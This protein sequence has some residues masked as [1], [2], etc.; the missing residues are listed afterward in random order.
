VIA[1]AYLAIAVVL[2]DALATRWFRPVTWFHRLAAAFLIGLLIATWVTYLTSLLFDGRTEDP[3]LV[4]NLASGWALALAAIA[5][6]RWVP[7]RPDAGRPRRRIRAWDVITL[8]AI[9]LLVTWMMTSTYSYSNGELGIATGLWSDF[10]PTTAIAQNFALG[11]NFPTEYPHYAGEAIRYHFLFYFQVGNLTYLGLDPA[12]ANNVLSIGSMLAMLVLVTALG[13]RLFRNAAVGRIGAALFF[14]HGAL[15]FI[16]YLAG[17]GSIDRIINDVPNLS[18]FL[19][20]G[21]PYRGEEWGIWSQIVFLNQRH[22]ASAIGILLVIVIFLLDRIDRDERAAPVAEPAPVSD[23]EPTVAADAE[24]ALAADAVPAADEAAVD[25][26]RHPVAVVRETLADPWLGGYVLCGALAGMLPLWNGAMFIGAAALLAVWLVIF[27]RRPSM[28]VL[29]VVA[30]VVAIPQLLWVRPGTMA[31]AQTYPSFYWG[32]IVDDPNLFNVAR[33]LAFTFGPKLLLVAFAFVLVTWRERRVLIAFVALGAVAFLLQL[34]VEVL[35]NHKFINAWLIVANLFVAYGLIRLWQARS[36]VAV[37]ARFVALGL[38]VIIVAGG[39]IDLM[40]VKNQFVIRVGMQGDRL[41]EWVRNETDRNAVFLTDLHVVHRIL[42][43]GRRI[44]FGW[45]YY[46]WSAGYAVRERED[47]Y[48]QLFA[49][50]SP[51]DVVER[52]QAAGIDYVAFDDGLRERGFAQR[53]NQEVFDGYLQP[54]FTDP[55]NRYNNTT[56][57]RVPT[58]P[59]AT[60]DLPDAPAEDMY[61]GGTGS[62][63]GQFAEPRGIALDKLKHIYVADTGNGRVQEF[64]SDGSLVRTIGQAGTGEGQ[65]D[66]PTGVAVT[67]NGH[68][69][70]A[71]GDGRV[72]E[73]DADGTHVRETRGP[74]PGFGPLADIVA[75][76]NRVFVLDPDNGRVVRIDENG[77]EIAFGSVGDGPDQLREPT[78][79][80]ASSS[81]IYVADTGNARVAVFN[82]DGEPRE[83]WSVPE[84]V[85]TTDRTADVTG[86]GAGRVWLTNPAGDSILVYRDGASVGT[87]P[88]QDPPIDDPAGIVSAPGNALFV[89]NRTPGRVSMVTQLDP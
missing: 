86:D 5:V 67:T 3:L 84:W 37:P 21:F 62:A 51:R 42:L 89:V 61:T 68:I 53:M 85:G 25:T 35:A 24:P 73:Y 10:G 41:F 1:L 34:S 50:R 70:V 14:F 52:L 72:H 7:R 8:V 58:E 9:G 22:L 83:T 18:A 43:A 23:N 54:V 77:I 6:Y 88:V 16:P 75:A 47:W 19:A 65:L 33:Y 59:A 63:P 60:L 29:A 2:G 80:G 36:V 49:D 4:G 17:L 48:R 40:P 30:S 71:T 57:Y 12:T 28:L 56:V 69:H 39:V 74:A 64:S 27:P 31:G 32:Y 76:G 79:I 11:D 82:E 13:E 26:I 46:A 87:L 20:S 15:S 78:G 44:Y 45:P 55:D 81:W 38:V 66:R